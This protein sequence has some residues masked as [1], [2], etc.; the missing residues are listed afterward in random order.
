ML[1]ANATAQ[2]QAQYSADLEAFN[3]G[4][5]FLRQ[6]FPG[7]APGSTLPRHP[8]QELGLVKVDWLLTPK[9]TLTVS[10]NVLVLA[11]T[12]ACSPLR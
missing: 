9:N 2:Q 1:P 11:P 12:T 3:A 10:N 6:Q 7:G 8:N 4:V 5:T